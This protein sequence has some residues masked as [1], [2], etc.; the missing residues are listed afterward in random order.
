[1][2]IATGK[3][4]RLREAQLIDAFEREEGRVLLGDD[5]TDGATDK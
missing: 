1:M 3:L 5:L 4:S 2:D